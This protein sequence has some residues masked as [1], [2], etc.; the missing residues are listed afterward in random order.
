MT[1]IEWVHHPLRKNGFT[2]FHAEPR[3]DDALVNLVTLCARC[4]MAEHGQLFYSAPAVKV[5]SKPKPRVK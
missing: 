2:P 5:C 4:H 1:R 3:Q